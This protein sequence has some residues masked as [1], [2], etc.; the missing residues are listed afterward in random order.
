MESYEN[1]LIL[2]FTQNLYK[3]FN[4]KY[5]INIILQNSKL[6]IYIFAIIVVTFN[7]FKTQIGLILCLLYVCNQYIKIDNYI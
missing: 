3:I 1:N 7:Y 4:Q 5:Q 6:K 2:I